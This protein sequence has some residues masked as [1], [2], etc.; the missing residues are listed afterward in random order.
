MKSKYNMGRKK[1]TNELKEKNGKKRDRK[2][3]GEIKNIC[4]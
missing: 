1:A 4:E 3:A 2:K